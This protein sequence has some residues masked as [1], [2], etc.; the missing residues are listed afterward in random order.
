MAP[1]REWFEKDYYKILGVTE[2]ATEK[3]IT[4]AYRKLAKELHPDLNS[5]A[6]ERFK[7]VTNAHDVLSDKKKREEYD[8][9]RKLGPVSGRIGGYNSGGS[10][11]FRL[12][13]LGD[14]FNGIFTNSGSGSSKYGF[15]VKSNSRGKDIEATLNL[16]FLEAATGTLANVLVNEPKKCQTCGGS[17]SKPGTNPE[18]C[19]KCNGSGILQDNQGLFSLAS[20]CPECRGTGL[21]ITNPCQTCGGSGIDYSS[22]NV[23]VRVPPGVENQQKIRVKGK[24]LP[25]SN[26]GPNGDLYVT[27]NVA[28]HEIFG[29][30]GKHLTIKVPITYTEA[31]LGANVVVPML[32][33]DPLTLK[34]PPGTSSGRSFRVKAKGIK[35]SS[36]VGDL[37]VTVEVE[38]PKNLNEL[39][40]GEVKKLENALKDLKSPRD[41]LDKYMNKDEVAK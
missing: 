17:G 20:T 29:R 15:R 16:S 11:S 32:E 3:E 9:L 14:M 18:V 27:I 23:K 26:Q 28:N 22:K 13:D 6:E 5:G 33:G 10:T 41:Y 2:T 1:E 19:K 39:Q 21:K 31:V 37:I 12:D 25:G 30:N 34:I 8:E 24:G 35:S 4:R 7:E 36:T 38:V 40:K